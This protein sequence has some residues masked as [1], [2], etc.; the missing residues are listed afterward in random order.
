MSR[1]TPGERWYQRLLRLYP[2][3]FR[4]EFGGAM[5]Q[6][7]RDRGQEERWW[8]L[9][10]SLVVDLLRTA[11]SEHLS[12][13]KQD[14]RHAGR[15]LR[16]TPIIT[17]T[18]V[19]T[20]ALGVGASTVVFG[21]VH[22]ILLRPLPY[23][24]PDRLVELFEDNPRTGFMRVSAL[25]YL[26]WAERSQRFES[27]GAFSGAGATLTGEGDPELLGGSRMTSSLFHVLRVLPLVG[28]TLQSED[29]QRGSPRVV[30][31]SESFWRSRFG[32]DSQIVGRSITLDGERHQVVGVMPRAFREVGRTQVAA[33]ADAQIF[34]PMTIDRTQENRANH[35]LRV[36][37]RLR[38]GV[39][40]DQ[41]RDE[42]RAVAAAMEQEFP[43]TN[44]NWGVRIDSLS[45]TMLGPQVRSSLLLMLGAVT[46]VFLIASANVANLL[47]AR[48]ARRHT[49]L[50][51]RTALGAGRSRLVRQLLTESGCLAVIS[52]AAGVL[53]AA[54]AQPLVRV[55]LPPTLPRLDEM[56]VDVIVLAFGLLLSMVSGL[57]FGVVPALRA[58]R[59]D[60]SRSL[61][62]AGRAT[63]DSSR[64]RLR[65]TLVVAQ[66]ALATMLLVGAVL[67]LQGFVRLHRV[68][69]GFEPDGVLTA[70]LSLPRSGYPDA[71]RAA[72]FYERLIATLH[73]SGQPLIV[74]VATSAP[75]APGV[76]AA[77]RPPDRDQGLAGGTGNQTAAE[78]A[79]EHIV[80][81]D[82]FRVLGVPLLAG[83]SFNEGDRA[84]SAA[85][86]VVSQRFARMFWPNTDPLRQMVDRSGQQ[87][88]VV[89]VVGD[90]RGSDTQGPR[91]A[92]PDREPRAAVYFAA[93]QLPQQTMTLLVRPTGEPS[94]VV[95]AS[96]REAVRQLDPTLAVQ[97]LRPLRDWLAESVAPTRL[98]TTF[99]SLFALSA[100]LLT[101][102]GIYGV[103]AYTVASRTREIGVRMA[104]G[105]TRRRV[106]GLIVREG[107]TWAA[108][109]I[110]VGLIG[111]FAAA[112]LIATLL[113]EV[114][115][116]D[117]VTFATVGVLVAL[118][119][120]IACA[121]PA[122]RAVRIDPTLA[123]RAE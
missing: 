21:V 74:A 55:W 71:A 88:Q 61:T 77:Y 44:T 15:G 101:A 119:A 19:L 98:T 13:L 106:L 60:V 120:L 33:T 72:Q 54:I 81:G 113:F 111:A 43:A 18:A 91:G 68:P 105:A 27:I 67:L 46:M 2:R 64:V 22:A 70:R 45:E 118:V 51:V 16:R 97:Q 36:V 28:R 121:I 116:H 115:A 25:N 99:A 3:D 39:T 94:S 100:L 8:S 20:L 80:S 110:A 23:P 122:A 47:L 86:A 90:I 123:M 65:E 83:R 89:G 34:L 57:V 63:A 76:R 78:H 87:Y 12:I 93:S 59:L 85:V 82:Y 75:F 92:G 66:I 5:A 40:L 53:V 69:L 48:G 84:G 95:I 1:Q 41:A 79:A 9:W 7:Y 26:S 108:S 103:L 102:V 96:L 17:A 14:L 73:G 52:G 35:T 49:E 109:G 117:P 104:M 50:A 37:G 32:G 29:E 62:H 112:R 24:E 56:R 38:R 11:P 42:M 4:D 114:P 30:V 58:S 10:Y 6:L 107:M 31:L